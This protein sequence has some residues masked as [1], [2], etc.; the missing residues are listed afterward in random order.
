MDVHIGEVT[1]TVRATDPATFLAPE[2]LERIVRLV[3]QHVREEQAR[4]ERAR[5]DRRFDSSR[6]VTD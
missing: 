4:D 5:S 1:S 6:L 2:V 3:L